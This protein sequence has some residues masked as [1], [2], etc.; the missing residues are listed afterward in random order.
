MQ[1]LKVQRYNRGIWDGKEPCE[2]EA[3]EEEHA[4]EQACGEALI[5]I[6]KPEQL[7]AN[8]WPLSKPGART[9]FGLPPG[10]TQT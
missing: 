3:Q 8:V 4:A 2:I 1:K 7:C 6:A 10:R 9:G 5:E